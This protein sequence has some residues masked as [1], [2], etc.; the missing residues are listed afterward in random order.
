MINNQ[1]QHSQIENDETP[2][3]EYPIE[4]DSEEKETN[5]TSALPNF[6]S[7]ILPDD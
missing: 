6:T 3:V 1:G 4:S 5:K 7:Q 2:G